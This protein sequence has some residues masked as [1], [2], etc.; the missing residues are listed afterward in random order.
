MMSSRPATQPLP[1]SLVREIRIVECDSG[2]LAFV[3]WHGGMSRY[4]RSLPVRVAERALRTGELV[5]GG[6]S[7]P[8]IEYAPRETNGA[9]V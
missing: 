5:N 8:V 3:R 1:T 9:R 4:W 2:R 7:G 6:F